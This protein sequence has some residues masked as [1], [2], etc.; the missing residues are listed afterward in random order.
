MNLLLTRTFFSL[1][2]PWIA[3]RARGRQLVFD[4]AESAA[5]YKPLGIAGW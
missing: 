2:R 3:D 1:Q 5:L 4:A